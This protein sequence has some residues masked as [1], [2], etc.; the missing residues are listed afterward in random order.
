[1]HQNFNF[2]CNEINKVKMLYCEKY[3]TLKIEQEKI[4]EFWNTLSIIEK[5]K[6]LLIEDFFIINDILDLIKSIYPQVKK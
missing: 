3:E 2:T 6:I 1:M 4:E 5:E